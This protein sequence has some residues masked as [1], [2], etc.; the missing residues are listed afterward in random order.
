MLQKVLVPLDESSFAEQA[1]PFAQRLLAPEGKL[2][3]MTVVEENNNLFS[4]YKFKNTDSIKQEM[5]DHAT[6]YLKQLGAVLR[7]DTTHQVEAEIRVGAPSVCIVEA[8]QDYEVDAIV[9][10]TRGQSDFNR[11]LIG[12]VTQKVL[13]DAQCPVVVVP[14]KTM[15]DSL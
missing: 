9:M 5:I 13:N 6:E 2:I 3:I 4:R 15:K 8:A 7:K 10:S 14:A 12:S 11:L 1:I